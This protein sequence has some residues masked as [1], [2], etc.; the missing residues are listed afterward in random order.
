MPRSVTC[1]QCEASLPV[2]PERTQF[3]CSF[4]GATVVVPEPTGEELLPD[5]ELLG[6]ES[7]AD[8]DEVIKK[9]VDLSRFTIDKQGEDLHISWKWSR[10]G[11]GCLMFFAVFW[12]GITSFAF[13]SGATDGDWI[14]SV[15]LIPFVGI[16]LLIAYA[17]LAY[18]I[19]STDIAV[20]DRLL[21]VHHGPLPWKN[22]KPV[23]VANIKQLF[24]FEK[25]TQ[26]KYGP[27]YSY[28]LHALQFEGPVLTLLSG[29]QG[30]EIPRAIERLL[31]VHLGIEDR[32]VQD[33]HA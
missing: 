14:L 32:R 6:D 4:C 21:T 22:P 13:L 27:R 18:L 15:F 23:E 31:E 24:C 5:D 26:G 8:D 16:G 2:P 11:G 7:A 9:P 1:P 28:E 10:L 25:V 20:E 3:F 29:E 33:E 12:L 19:N 17:A 30:P